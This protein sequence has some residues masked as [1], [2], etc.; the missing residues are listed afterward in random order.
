MPR[1]D[2]SIRRV[3]RLIG[4]LMKLETL[5]KTAK[6]GAVQV[7]DIEAHVPSPECY[8]VTWGQKDGKMQTKVT[9]CKPKNIGKS[10][11]TTATEQALVEAK[12]YWEKKCKA[13]YSTNESAPVIVNLPMKVHTY[14]KQYKK[15]EFP[16]FESPKLNGVNAT[17]K[18]ID[19]GLVLLSRGGENYPLIDQHLEDIQ[20]IMEDLEVNELNGEIYIH[21][22]PLQDI[23]SAVKKYNEHTSKLEFHIFDIP[24]YKSEY[25]RRLDA[26]RSIAE[27]EFVK[28]VPAGTAFNHEEL[29]TL[30]DDY[31]KEGYE[32][33]MVRN[34]KGLYVHNTRSYDVQKLKK[35]QDAEFKVVGHNIDK[36]G[37]AVFIC[38]AGDKTFKVKLKGTAEERLAMA[39]KAESYYNQWLKIEFEMYSKDNIPLKPV[40]I[41]FR[42]CDTEGNPTE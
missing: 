18:W 40:G 14:E 35:A 25:T 3:I 7:M 6:S 11:E 27:T 13:N 21:G 9:T 41:M 34:G 24:A 30:H 22:L 4:K 37:H 36:N 16:C 17:Y 10:N 31:V 15:I 38:E 42:E 20:K 19:D 1:A 33:L 5:Y 28:V 39:A 2:C 29:D 26:M 8:T 32:G 12:A 23:T